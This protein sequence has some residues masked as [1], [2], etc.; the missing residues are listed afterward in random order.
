MLSLSLSY[1]YVQ[2]PLYLRIM[3]VCVCICACVHVFVC[4]CAYRLIQPSV[5]TSL[6]IVYVACSYYAS[7]LSWMLPRIFLQRSPLLRGP[8]T[9]KR[10]RLT[11][12]PDGKLMC[13]V[14]HFSLRTLAYPF[15]GQ[16]ASTL[17]LAL[18]PLAV[19]HVEVLVAQSW[20]LKSHV[21]SVYNAIDLIMYIISYYYYY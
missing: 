15:Q 13:L 21:V 2:C 18:R 5:S 7:R 3:C 12:K 20:A 14:T 10:K 6:G 17:L 9:G 11:R 1:T 8:E 19:G 4:V 16:R